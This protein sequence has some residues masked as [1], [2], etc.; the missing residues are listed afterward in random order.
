[1]RSLR[2]RRCCCRCSC[3]A[4]SAQ[5]KKYEPIDVKLIVLQLHQQLQLQRLVVFRLCFIKY[6][7]RSSRSSSSI[8]SSSSSSRA[9]KVQTLSSTLPGSQHILPPPPISQSGCLSVRL[10]LILHAASYAS[11]ATKFSSAGIFYVAAKNVPTGWQ[12]LEIRSCPR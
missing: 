5:P 3:F 6:N 8:S 2:Q 1:M 12:G 9:H 4:A 11:N 10:S 7:S